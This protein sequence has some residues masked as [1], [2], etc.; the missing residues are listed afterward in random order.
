[1]SFIIEEGMDSLLSLCLRNGFE[2]DSFWNVHLVHQSLI[3]GRP[4]Y[5]VK[6]LNAGAPLLILKDDIDIIPPELLNR[7]A[8]Y[9]SVEWYRDTIDILYKTGKKS[10]VKKIIKNLHEHQSSEL[11]DIVGWILSVGDI[12]LMKLYISQHYPT[13]EYNEH[14]IISSTVCYS[15]DWAPFFK[16]GV[17][18]R[19]EFAVEVF[20]KK[21]VGHCIFRRDD[22]ALLFWIDRFHA[23]PT[24]D[25]MKTLIRQLGGETEDSTSLVQELLQRLRFQDNG[26]WHGNSDI[27]I[28]GRHNSKVS[29]S[30]VLD[31]LVYSLRVKDKETIEIAT[32]TQSNLFSEPAAFCRIYDAAKTIPYADIQNK[33]YR[34]LLPT[35]RII[36]S[37]WDNPEKTSTIPT[38]DIQKSICLAKELID[39]MPGDQ[40]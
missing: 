21:A 6:L 29:H 15:E 12:G 28:E 10:L 11:A 25:Q 8:Q 40:V 33:I 22:K 24:R 9:K 19:D 20:V 3:C 35:A 14:M 17:L 39:G 16:E 34:I 5:A 37:T 7:L 18:F 32:T 26:E 4:D 23:L 30:S 27:S 1:M 36:V 2:P 38:Y 31:L 13:L